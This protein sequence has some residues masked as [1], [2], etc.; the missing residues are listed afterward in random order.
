M[1]TACDKMLLYRVVSFVTLL[2]C[3]IVFVQAEKHLNANGPFGKRHTV[4]NEPSP[5]A[6]DRGAGVS[7][8]VFRQRIK[9][10]QNIEV[11]KTLYMSADIIQIKWTPSTPSC[12]DDFVGIYYAEVPLTSGK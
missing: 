7:S 6:C 11:S 4:H 12:K 9:R 10:V 1:V 2:S 8:S 5:Y 3:S